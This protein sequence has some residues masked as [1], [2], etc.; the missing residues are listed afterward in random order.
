MPCAV[1]TLQLAVKKRLGI[2]E[3]I[4]ITKK[5]SAIVSAFKHLYKKKKPL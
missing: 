2:D 1:H 3:C 5:A 4:A